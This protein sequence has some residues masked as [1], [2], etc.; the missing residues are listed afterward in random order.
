MLSSHTVFTLFRALT[1]QPVWN[2]VDIPK[3]TLSKWE[4]DTFRSLPNKVNSSE[5]N[6]AR[7]ESMVYSQLINPSMA[8]YQCDTKLGSDYRQSHL[9]RPHVEDECST[10]DMR[11]TL[12]GL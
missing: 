4:R 5:H 3:T 11:G 8:A 1:S 12:T 9:A 7:R 2:D 10:K 6:D